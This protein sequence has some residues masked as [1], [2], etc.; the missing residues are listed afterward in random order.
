[1]VRAIEQ[2]EKGGAPLL[3]GGASDVEQITGPVTVDG[4][5]ETSDVESYAAKA[6]RRRRVGAGW[7]VKR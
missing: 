5:C 3:C 4:I 7:K 6:D 1:L 2:V